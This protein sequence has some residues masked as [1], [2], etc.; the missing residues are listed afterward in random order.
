MSTTHDNPPERTMT[1]VESTTDVERIFSHQ[2]SSSSPLRSRRRIPISK[3]AAYTWLSVQK[4]MEYSQNAT[5]CVTS[6]R[7][8]F[9]PSDA[10]NGRSESELLENPGVPEHPS[11]VLTRIASFSTESTISSGN[12]SDDSVHKPKPHRAADDIPN[13][14][15]P[16]GEKVDSFS[17]GVPEDGVSGYVG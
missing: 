2:I 15:S 10:T 4:I 11:L 8:A 17:D 14:S 7:Q 1:V 12:V 9:Y 5:G 13:V 6:S 16:E 3:T